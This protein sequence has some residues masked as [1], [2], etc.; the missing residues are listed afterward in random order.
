[1]LQETTMKPRILSW[2]TINPSICVQFFHALE[3]VYLQY[4][5]FSKAR[6]GWGRPS[7][8]WAAFGSHLWCCWCCC[9]CTPANRASSPCR[10]RLSSGWRQQKP[11]RWLAAFEPRGH[12]KP[13]RFILVH[14]LTG[15]TCTHR[16][17]SGRGSFAH[18]CFGQLSLLLWKSVAQ[19]TRRSGIIFW[20]AHLMLKTNCLLLKIEEDTSCAH[21]RRSTQVRSAQDN[22]TATSCSY[23]IRTLQI[24]SPL[25]YSVSIHFFSVPTQTSPLLKPV[26]RGP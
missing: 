7:W 24:S 22:T 14:T 25:L 17:A 8:F 5:R 10:W 3:Q 18:T 6:S 13:L 20:S 4:S 21:S 12:T 15:P 9:R 26:A 1:M 23:Q 2:I 19:R 16:S 11:P